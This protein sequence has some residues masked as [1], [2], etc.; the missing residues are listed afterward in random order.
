M[1]TDFVSN[2]TG[3]YLM[4]FVS[5]IWMLPLAN[6]QTWTFTHKFKLELVRTYFFLKLACSCNVS[7]NKWFKKWQKNDS[8]K[9]EWYLKVN[10]YKNGF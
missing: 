4:H 8:A 9:A 1:S 7:T 3:K 10:N 6:K 2:M 5:E